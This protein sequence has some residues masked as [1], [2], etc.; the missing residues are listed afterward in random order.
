MYDW[1]HQGNTN[2]RGLSFLR[3]NALADKH[4]LNPE[5]LRMENGMCGTNTAIKYQLKLISTRLIGSMCFHWKQ[6]HQWERHAHFYCHSY[7]F[8]SR[9]FKERHKYIVALELLDNFL[10]FSCGR[11]SWKRVR[12]F[13]SCV[14]G[15]R[16]D[17]LWLL[18][19]FC[20]HW[21]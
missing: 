20:L 9:Y 1:I 16:S 12:G 18:T 13:V 4:A 5:A 17:P 8:L 2:D 11:W 14:P 3:L 21:F 15:K 6:L 7:S 19:M 10:C